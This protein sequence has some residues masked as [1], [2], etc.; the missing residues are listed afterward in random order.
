M[1]FRL[2]KFPKELETLCKDSSESCSYNPAETSTAHLDC[3]SSM[4]KEQI[5][6]IS[7]GPT[8]PKFQV[9]RN[10]KTFKILH[11]YPLWGLIIL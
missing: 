2:R 4:L 7:T 1:L 3:V 9:S 11:F 10:P 5:L 8:Y 6:D